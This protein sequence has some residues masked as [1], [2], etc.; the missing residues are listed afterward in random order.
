[1]AKSTEKRLHRSLRQYNYQCGGFF[2]RAL[3]GRETTGFRYAYRLGDVKQTA[4]AI[5]LKEKTVCYTI[6][7]YTREELSP[8][9]RPVF[10]AVLDSMELS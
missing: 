3:C 7:Y 2:Q 4:E 8:A 10:E 6:Y 5:I 1:M 9:S